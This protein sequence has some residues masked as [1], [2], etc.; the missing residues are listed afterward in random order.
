[1][2]E[3]NFSRLLIKCLYH[4][5]VCETFYKEFEVTEDI[6]NCRTVK[7]ERCT[8]DEKGNEWC[9]NVPR[10]VCSKS[11]GPSKKVMPKTECRSL[12]KDVC[13]PETCPIVKGDR[14]CRNE[15]KHVCSSRALVLL[16]KF[17]IKFLPARPRDPRG[18]MQPGSPGNLQPCDQDHPQPG[19]H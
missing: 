2:N 16:T 17:S 13:G 14:K 19:P 12:P 7:E 11:T 10:Q 1:M 15:I 5:I 3:D 6:A 8:M 18:G 4:I 9:M